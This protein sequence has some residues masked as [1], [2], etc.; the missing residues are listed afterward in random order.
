MKEQ[1]KMQNAKGKSENSPSLSLGADRYPYLLLDTGGADVAEAKSSPEG[2]AQ[3]N[4]LGSRTL[5][6]PA[7]PERAG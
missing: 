5:A 1:V 7:S 2:A 4:G 3:A 6:P